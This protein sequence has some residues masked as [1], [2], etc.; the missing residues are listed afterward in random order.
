MASEGLDRT[1]DSPLNIASDSESGTESGTRAT[2]L[3]LAAILAAWPA[4]LPRERQLVAKIAQVAAAR[5][6]R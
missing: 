1:P 3:D 2:D 6:A 5:A 4:M